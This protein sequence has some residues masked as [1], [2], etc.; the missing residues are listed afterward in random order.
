MLGIRSLQRGDTIIEVMLAFAVFSMLAVG[1]LTVMGQ[2]TNASQRA[3][4]ITLV[5]QQI[6]AQAEA[7]R[8]AHQADTSTVSDAT[9]P[10]DEISIGTDTD[11]YDNYDTDCPTAKP[12]DSFLMD[13]RTGT[14][15]QNGEGLKSVNV[16]PTLP[17]AHVDYSGAQPQSYGIWIER[18]FIEGGTLADSY[19]FTVQACWFG[20]GLETPLHIETV[21]RLYE[22]G[23]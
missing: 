11:A 9:T 15:I 17:H 10:W 23:S 20:A 5:R 19:S 4:E 6:D 2:G 22:P 14:V 8:A 18:E 7:L 16:S 3:L 21:V 1:A 12:T 13:A